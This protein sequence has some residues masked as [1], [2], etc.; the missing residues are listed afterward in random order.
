M[1]TNISWSNYIV[2]IVLF[3]AGWYVFIGLRFYFNDLR[4]IATWKRKLQ[5]RGLQNENFQE[6]ESQLNSQYLPQATSID[7][8]FEEFDTTLE[9]VDALVDQLKIVIADAA[10][11][12]LSRQEFA[13]HLK[14]V[15][16]QYPLIKNSPLSSSVSELI[17]SECGKLEYAVLSQSEAE[18]LW[19]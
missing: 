16:A 19:N 15:L 17:V 12:K 4:E 9:D 8:P 1:F 18:A 14:L 6:P 3:T 2:V 10:K 7:S 11:T 13:R 5:F